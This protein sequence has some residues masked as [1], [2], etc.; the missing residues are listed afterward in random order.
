MTILKRVGIAQTK[1]RNVIGM[2]GVEANTDTKQIYVKLAKQW[3]RDNMPKIVPDIQRLHNTIKW[4]KTYIDV[5]V[6]A[7][8]ITS[9]RKYRVPVSIV[10]VQRDIKD[11]T[12]MRGA[13]KMDENEM[14]NWTLKI[15]QM[16]SIHSPENPT[17]TMKEYFTQMSIYSEHTTEAGHMA[18]YAP[19]N[20]LDCL[21]KALMI[22]LYSL[23]HHLSDNYVSHVATHSIP[24]GNDNILSA[25]GG[26]ALSDTQEAVSPPV[27][28]QPEG[29]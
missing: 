16:G 21:P 12:M 24:R 14:V 13:K 27:I 8:T 17:D 6:G 18:H 11:I 28:T 19:G 4:S 23:R 25:Y 22:V 29:W 9:L 2:I 26:S 10:S 5:L 20:E 1:L 3:S 7:N 15:L